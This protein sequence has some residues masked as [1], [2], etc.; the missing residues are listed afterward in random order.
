MDNITIEVLTEND[1]KEYSELINEV[2]EEFNKDEI[3]GFQLWFAGIE[4][5]TH[6]RRYGF[7]DGSLDTVQFA[8]KHEGKIIGAL[9]VE[10]K[11]HI[12]SFFV[13]KEFQN[14]GIGKMLLKYSLDF[15]DANGITVAVYCVVASDYAVDIYK[16]LGFK[17]EG[18]WLHLFNGQPEET[19]P[20][21]FF[22]KG[23]KWFSKFEGD[24]PWLDEPELI[25]VEDD[26]LYQ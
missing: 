21:F 23:S 25:Y 12:Q 20:F 10:N 17:G 5:I 19:Y 3:D 14:K 4:G 11:E 9:E 1:I 22:A 8:A 15:F 16:S 2:M 6:R 26:T 24:V 18:K 13:K 7:D